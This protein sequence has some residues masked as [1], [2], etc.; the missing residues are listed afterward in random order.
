[1]SMATGLYARLVAQ[2]TSAEK[3][4]PLR[5]PEDPELPALTYQQIAGPREYSHDGEAGPHRLRWQI[6]AWGETYEAAKE[7]A[8]E[9]VLALS[10][11]EDTSGVHV[12]RCVAFI[13]NEIDLFDEDAELFYVPIDA[14]ILVEVE[15]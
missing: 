12:E 15:R 8:E 2:A 7:L 6:T 3:V 1:M 4:Y 11:W 5:L 9:V 10:A 13:A 14:V